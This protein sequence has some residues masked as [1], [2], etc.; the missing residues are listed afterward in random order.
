MRVNHSRR[1][2]RFTSVHDACDRS[3]EASFGLYQKGFLPNSRRCGPNLRNL[4]VTVLLSISVELQC[5]LHYTCLCVRYNY[6]Y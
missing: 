1:V 4:L 5:D 3:V 6:L 2:R